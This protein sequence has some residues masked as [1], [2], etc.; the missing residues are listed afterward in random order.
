MGG[1]CILPS[2]LLHA[3]LEPA[4]MKRCGNIAVRLNVRGQRCRVRLNVRGQRCRVR[5][6]VHGQ[7]CSAPECAWAKVQCVN[8]FDEQHNGTMV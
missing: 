2:L 1:T 7:R 5:L 8:V 6:N 3:Q 4:Q